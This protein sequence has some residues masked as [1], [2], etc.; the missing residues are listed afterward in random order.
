MA[1]ENSQAFNT[2]S[3]RLEK[4]EQFES[5]AKFEVSLE[6]LVKKIVSVKGQARVVSLEKNGSSLTI[7]GKTNYQ[8]VYQT[9]NNELSSVFAEADWVQ[10]VEHLGDNPYVELFV[11]ENVVT[12]SSASE[13]AVSSLIKYDIYDV[14]AEKIETI[15][16][17]SDDYVVK[18]AE[19]DFYRV[20]NQVN[21]S[22]NEV[23]EVEQS[24]KVSSVLNYTGD[25][26]LKNVSA[27]IDAIT[28]E[29]EIV[30]CVDALADGNIISF[31][32]VI[33]FK[34]EVACLSAVPNHLV[35]SDLILSGL[36]VT[37]SVNETDSKTTFVIAVMLNASA[38]VYSKETNS[39]IVD[40]FSIEN[41]IET[42]TECV[43]ATCYVGQS[44][45]M[46]SFVEILELSENV[47][48][49]KFVTDKKVYVTDIEN[50]EDLS[51]LKGNVEVKFV[52]QTEVGDYKEYTVFVPFEN[53]VQKCFAE[54]KFNACIDVKNIKLKGQNEVEIAGDLYVDVKM[55]KNECITY[56]SSITETEPKEKSDA[57]IKVLV[58]RAGEDLFAVSKALSVKPEL[59]L[60]QNPN[61][62]ENIEPNTK[63]VV[64]SALD[65]SF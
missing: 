1:F 43:L 50:K 2:E 49:L 45:S 19:N 8:V 6:N 26:R 24:G 29:G 23:S 61:L 9:E 25:V 35:D 17:F 4:S 7:N 57:G 59:V 27:G 42:T 5:M 22:F 39:V 28:F 47:E 30:V 60:M 16:N 18:H 48:S 37:A 33:D 14:H 38:V 40:V 44:Q 21:Q 31:N 58:S 15:E 55:F 12:G 20:V 3:K 53:E 11:M 51:V 41:N 32:K 10:R 54:D 63:I 36:K 56:V 13:I 62:S 64:Y 65:V 52:G 46:H 34:E